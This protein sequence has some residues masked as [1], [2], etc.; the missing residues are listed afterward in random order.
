M[1]SLPYQTMTPFRTFVLTAGLVVMLF[2]FSGCGGV[3][4]PAGQILPTAT[5][6]IASPT[7]LPPSDTPL[8]PTDTPVP[9]TETGTPTNTATQPP[10][11]TPAPTATPTE[12]IPPPTASGDQAVYVYYILKDDGGPVGCGDTAVKINTGAYRT[13]DVATDVAVA[14]NRLFN[15]QQYIGNLYNPVYLSNW[16]VDSVD[17]KAYEGQ[18][19]VSLSGGY[20]RSGDRCDD[21][22]V[23]A[24]IWST[25]RQFPGVKTVYILMNGNLLGDIL[26]TGK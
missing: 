24:Q 13:G 14:L 9:P 18:V 5:Q 22:R 2:L 15:K 25:I 23:R 20:V 16:R 8:P 17:F 12:T 21:S 19:N 3:S 26:A 7:L 6:E 11:D 4:Q 1:D 10:T